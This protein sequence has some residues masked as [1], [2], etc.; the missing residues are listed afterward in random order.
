LVDQVDSSQAQ[1]A[2]IVPTL[3]VKY[4]RRLPGEELIEINVADF[5][6]TVKQIPDQTANNKDLTIKDEAE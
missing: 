5:E 4:C 6:V 1:Q 2:D 3:S